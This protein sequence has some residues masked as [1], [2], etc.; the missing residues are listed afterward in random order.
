MSPLRAHDEVAA[1]LRES[2][3][4]KVAMS[5]RDADTICRI[6]DAIVAAYRAHKKV[7]MFGNGGSAADAQH[8]VAELLGR[9]QLS[10]PA[11]PA[12]ALTTNSSVVT[13]IG[14]D[15]G[16]ENVF[17]RQIEAWAQEGD[18]VI[19]LSTSGTSRN[20]L[21]AVT[22]AKRRG[23]LTVALTGGTGGALT[24]AVDL[25]LIV[26]ASS[27]QRIQ[28]AHI[29]VGHVICSLVETALFGSPSP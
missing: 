9:F 2:A 27:P 16:F 4:V 8:I 7:I 11:L 3:A 14:N 25:A 28:E 19:A 13:A 6:A 29:T 26:P 17:S 15:F 20:V 10:R 21:A 5:D 12:L 18:V 24:G 23:A 1:Q 22:A